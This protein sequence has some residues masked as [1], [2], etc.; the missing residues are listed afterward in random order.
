MTG[1]DLLRR[2]PYFTG[3]LPERLQA[4]AARMRERRYQSGSVIFLRGA[5]SEGLYLVLSGRVAT[6]TVS[7]EG[8]EQVLHSFGPGKTFG[9]IAVFDGGPHP[10]TAQAM[11]ASTV[12]IIP[13]D[14]LFRLLAEH[15]VASLA[16]LRYFAVR[17]RAFTQIVEDLSLRPVVA[18]I[19]RRL[20]DLARGEGTMVEDTADLAPQITQQQ[21]AAMVGSVRV[22]VQRDLKLLERAGAIGLT[23]GRVRILDPR[24]LERWRDGRPSG[25]V[26]ASAPTARRSSR[27]GPAR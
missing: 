3:V 18:R 2:V 16:G 23:R 17:L 11:R 9:D 19:A 1:I 22:V 13:R 14:D 21:L 5:S 24:I 4:L 6:V 7:P 25:A 12:A 27:R 20:L 15:P 26:A 10:G 8:R